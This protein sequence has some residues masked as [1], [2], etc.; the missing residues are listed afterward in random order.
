[1]CTV[2]PR[3]ADSKRSCGP[4]NLST[5]DEA[6]RSGVLICRDPCSRARVCP[7]CARSGGIQSWA[8]TQST[9]Y[10]P[11]S[12]HSP[13]TSGG[14]HR[15][16]RPW[17]RLRAWQCRTPAV[18][19]WLPVCHVLCHTACSWPKAVAL[20]AS[21]QQTPRTI[22]HL[23]CLIVRR[24]DCW[25]VSVPGRATVGSMLGWPTALFLCRTPRGLAALCALC[26]SLFLALVL[27][28][29]SLAT[30]L[31]SLVMCVRLVASKK[32]I[33]MFCRHCGTRC[34]C[35]PSCLLPQQGPCVKV[36]CSEGRRVAVDRALFGR[37]LWEMVKILHPHQG[38]RAVYCGRRVCR[39]RRL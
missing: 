33:G 7:A 38:Q 11:C 34:R 32:R 10:R 19:T 5:H 17:P 12:I 37:V 8:P 15:A 28:G 23:P 20:P 29:I 3:V 25:A 22:G 16:P 2:A 4:C 36:A 35:L 9:L 24:P 39:L 1:M 14:V 6:A 18:A 30:R 13:A 31:L 27:R 26:P 21:C